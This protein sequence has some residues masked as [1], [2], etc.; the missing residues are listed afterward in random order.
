MKELPPEIIH[1]YYAKGSWSDYFVN[2]LKE[3]SERASCLRRKVGAIAVADRRIIATGYNGTPSGIAHCEKVGC[4]RIEK[5]VPSGERHE[6]CMDGDTKVKLLDG[7]FKTIRELTESNSDDFWVYS[8]KIGEG[9]V[10]AKAYHPRYVGK[11]ECVK[12]TLDNGAEIICTPDHKILGR[13]EKFIEASALE[14]GSSL[15]SLYYNFS[16]D[17]GYESVCTRKR[18]SKDWSPS[19]STPTHI[20]VKRAMGFDW[21]TKTHLVHHKNQNKN[22]NRPENLEI[23]SRSEHTKVHGLFASFSLEQRRENGK[24]GLESSLKNGLFQSEKFRNRAS[25]SAKEQWKDPKFRELMTEVNKANGKLTAEKTNSDKDCIARR[26]QGRI[27]SGI[28]WLMFKSGETLTKENY[29]SIMKKYPVRGKLGESGPRPPKMETILKWFPSF[30]DALEQAMI[31][32]HK[33]VSV[34]SVGMRDVYDLT[35]PEYE[36]Y[37]IYAGGMSCLFTHN[38]RAVHAE[39]N[40]IIQAAK[41]GVPLVDTDIYCTHLPCFIC[42]K[43]LVNCNVRS[44]YFLEGYPDDMTLDMYASNIASLPSLIHLQPEESYRKMKNDD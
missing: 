29:T 4:L 3:V 10:P 30:D 39:Q 8:Y 17:D 11:R 32:N 7:T 33:V 36:N 25:E 41:F 13:D 42:F 2:I 40:L 1:Q 21:D 35:V 16:R 14:S 26:S 12:I 44:I 27:V 38:C 31:Y 9:I 19:Y 34:E 6:I 28:S 18:Y 15:M 24:K 20:L 22:D 23:I 37:A 43:M 5:H